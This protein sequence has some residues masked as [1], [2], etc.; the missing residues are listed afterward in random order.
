MRLQIYA[1]SASGVGYQEDVSELKVNEISNWLR[2]R[3][4]M[5]M[6]CGFQAGE[7][8]ET[9]DDDDQAVAGLV[10]PTPRKVA[11]PSM[12]L[13]KS[14]GLVATITR[15]AP[16][17]AFRCQSVFKFEEEHQRNDAVRDRLGAGCFDGRQA[18]GQ[19]RVEDIV[20][21]RISAL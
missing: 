1:R 19:N 18:V 11:S 4:F 3:M 21:V 5:E 17:G 7:I 16:D 14:T 9:E 15:T 20:L 8:S 13:R 10:K 2:A 12:P 6:M